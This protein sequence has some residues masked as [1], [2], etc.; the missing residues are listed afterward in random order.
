MP[1]HFNMINTKGRSRNVLTMVDSR[2]AYPVHV[3]TTNSQDE[4]VI[5]LRQVVGAGHY[6][7]KYRTPRKAPD[8]F[9][10]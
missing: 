3:F 5:P 8:E 2:M 6:L 4:R 7:P 9:R 10:R 1:T